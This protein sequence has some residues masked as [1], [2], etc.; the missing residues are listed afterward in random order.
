MIESGTSKVNISTNGYSYINGGNVGIG[1]TNPGAK[2][3]VQG[4]FRVH[5]NTS[6]FGYDGL[7]HINS[8][9]TTHGSETVALQTTIDGRA[10]TEANPGTHGGESRN[11]IALQP[12][13]GYVGIGTISPTYK[14][15]VSGNCRFTGEVY[16]S[17]A[18][19]SDGNRSVIRGP[20]PTLYF[21]DTDHNSAM[22]HNNANLLYVLRGGNDTETWSQVNGQWP[23]IFNLTTNDSTCGGNLY[24]NGGHTIFGDGRGIRTITG[25][26]GTVQTTGTAVGGWSGYSIDG[27]YLFMSDGGNHSGIY[28]DIDNHW[29]ILN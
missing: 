22:L 2:L 25:Q 10:L 5:G 20:H 12:D 9:S 7:L 26:Y 16:T 1:T 27:K 11:V 21:R 24:V 29:H 18:F 8:R 14:L 6:T 28:N 13:G 3:S 17:S 23:W 4:S 19:Y 15:D